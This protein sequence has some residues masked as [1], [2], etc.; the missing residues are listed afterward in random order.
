[1]ASDLDH[2]TA[3]RPGAAHT[4]RP[5]GSRH[6][7]PQRLSPLEPGRRRTRG[8]GRR[9]VLAAGVLAAAGL[10]AAT[11]LGMVSPLASGAVLVTGLTVIGGAL[12][13]RG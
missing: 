6:V 7:G 4:L 2:S 12:A 5:M 9:R 8:R 10:L 13:R 3:R 1:V 11:L